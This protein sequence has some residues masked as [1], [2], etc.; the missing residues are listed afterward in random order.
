MHAWLRSI[1]ALLALAL[2][3]VSQAGGQD[4]AKDDTDKNAPL[5]GPAKGQR[6]KV[7]SIDRVKKSAVILGKQ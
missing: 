6:F 4:K 7:V 3:V 1:A 5:V 2:L